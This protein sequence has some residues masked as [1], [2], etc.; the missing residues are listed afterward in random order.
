M[1]AEASLVNRRLL[2]DKATSYP[3]V[4]AMVDRLR[5]AQIS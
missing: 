3:L 4:L 2:L 1:S 5:S